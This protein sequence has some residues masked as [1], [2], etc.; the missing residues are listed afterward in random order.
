MNTTVNNSFEQ[1]RRILR[2]L[3]PQAFL[4]FGVNLVA[5]VRPAQVMDNWVYV[6]HAA[7]GSPLAVVETLEAAVAAARQNDLDPVT[8]Q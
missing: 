5:Y 2:N 1:S 3:T 4:T 6:I 8:L 7:D